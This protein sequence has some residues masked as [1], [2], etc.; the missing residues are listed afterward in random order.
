MVAGAAD[1]AGKTSGNA[2]Q[3]HFVIDPDID[4]RIQFAALAGQQLLQGFRLGQGAGKAVQD[5]AVLA[6][7]PVESLIDNIDH[8]FIGHQA[9]AV[10]DFL[11]PA[12]HIRI[13]G[14]GGAHHGGQIVQFLDEQPRAPLILHLGDRDPFIPPAD[15]ERIRTAHPG[16]PVH[17]YPA[18][19][20]FNCTP[21]ADY[22][23]ESA[24]LAWR[25]TIEFLDEHLG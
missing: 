13:G 19:H 22:H 23:E 4:D 7:F 18:G 2:L 20:G 1:R 5:I 9:A 6:V 25:R 14:H 17:L 12:P 3:E 15:A 8:D 10:H 16:V 21:R 24:N 11:G